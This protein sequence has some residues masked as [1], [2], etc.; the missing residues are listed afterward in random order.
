MPDAPETLPRHVLERRLR[1]SRGLNVLLGAVAAAALVFGGVQW[2]QANGASGGSS[3]EASGAAADRSGPAGSGGAG[4]SLERRAQ[5]DT[6]AIGDID[7]PVVLSEWVDF[8]CPFCAVFSRD[9]LPLI[10][11]EYVDAGKV[12]IEMHDVAFFGEESTRAAAAARAA[13]E[14]GKYFEFLEAVYAAAPESGHPELPPKELIAHAKTAGVPDL[15]RFERDMGRD[16]LVAAVEESTAQAQR[17]GVTGV[18][19]FVVDGTGLS[20]AQPADAFRQVL[21]RA[22]ADAK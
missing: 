19:F 10:V 3:A 16:D 13:G 21:D 2:S 8:R 12:R 14:Q 11:Q 20:G 1:S 22:V 15:R 18:P 6:M 5:D 4:P 17:I 9:T 7:A